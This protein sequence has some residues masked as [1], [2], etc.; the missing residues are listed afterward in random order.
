MMLAFM[1]ARVGI[2]TTL[3]EEHEDF[4]RDFRGVTVHSSV[5]QI[6]DELGLAHRVLQLRHTKIRS[7][8]VDRSRLSISATCPPGS[9]T[10]H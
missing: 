6:L 7:I 3:L 1:L 2:E 9:R 8:R 10:S 4:D 5:L